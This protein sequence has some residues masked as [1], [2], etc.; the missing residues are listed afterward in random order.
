MSELDV[1]H[2]GEKK[3]FYAIK[4]IIQRYR[5]AAVFVY[6]T[7]VPALT[8]DDVHAVCAAA[9]ERFQ[10]AGDTGERAGLRGLQESR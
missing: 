1:I 6:V 5:P 10:H 2:G 8:G 7:C 4:E 9:A 3:L